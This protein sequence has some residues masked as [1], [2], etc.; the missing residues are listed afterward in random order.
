MSEA[1]DAAAK[2][3]DWVTTRLIQ[4]LDGDDGHPSDGAIDGVA[5][6]FLLR[7]YLSTDRVDL[8]DALAAALAQ[9]LVDAPADPT[10]TGRAAWLTLFVEASVV[11]DDERML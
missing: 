6:T 2:E 8:R 1:A 10:V 7:Q 3:L 11:A 4:A 5:L 9:A